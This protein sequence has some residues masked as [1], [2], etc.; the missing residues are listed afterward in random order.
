MALVDQDEASARLASARSGHLA[1]I[2][3][4]GRPHLVVITF[5]MVGDDVV[6]AIDEKPKTTQ[7]LQRLV[8]VEA[9]PAVSFLIDHYDEDWGR[10]WWVR[11]DGRATVHHDDGARDTAVEALVAKYPAYRDRPP[12]GAVI[13]ISRDRLSSW[14]YSG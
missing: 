8:N 6:T 14:A 2:R 10:L 9:N 5:A 1:T 11:V 4:N 7:R 3:P 13:S 12:Q